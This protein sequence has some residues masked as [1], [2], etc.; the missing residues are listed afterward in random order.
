MTDKGKLLS[1]IVAQS[2][3]LKNDVVDTKTVSDAETLLFCIMAP[4][5]KL[6]N[7]V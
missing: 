7:Y 4:S 2:G 5:G 1:H 6:G 3:K